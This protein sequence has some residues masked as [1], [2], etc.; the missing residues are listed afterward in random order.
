[1]RLVTE[2]LP[3]D[4]P[5]TLGTLLALP[6][7]IS[8]RYEPG[9]SL[10]HNS[11]LLS[12]HVPSP[13]PSP[14]PM[15]SYTPTPLREPS[16]PVS[17]HPM[18]PFSHRPTP[19][20]SRYPSPIPSHHPT[21]IPSR[22]LSALPSRASSRA[23][24]SYPDTTKECLGVAVKWEPGTIWDSYPFHQ[25]ENRFFPWRPVGVMNDEWLR[26]RSD[27]CS[28]RTSNENSVCKECSI[29]PHHEKF[30]KAVDRAT[31][32][33]VLGGNIP[34][35]FLSRRQLIA[36]NRATTEKLRKLRQ[37]VSEL[38]GDYPP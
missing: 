16:P 31:S 6:F 30:R 14:T 20:P 5:S 10:S 15:S 11:S 19:L 32:D 24:S 34:W 3:D 25:H 33:S 9:P 2:T 35:Q 17:N 36:H 38:G 27:T 13:S 28:R 18:P 8:P 7:E 26:L 4:F 29:I 12:S 22:Q 37:M 21:P 1:M 23:P